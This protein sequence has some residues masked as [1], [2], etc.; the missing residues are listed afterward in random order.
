MY[1]NMGNKDF[2]WIVFRGDE[3]YFECQRCWKKE[4][5]TNENEAK[6]QAAAFKD[7]HKNC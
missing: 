7:E 2:P 4:A 3:L 6:K 1:Q 5:L